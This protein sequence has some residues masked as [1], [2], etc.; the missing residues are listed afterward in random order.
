VLR[1][2]CR[3]ERRPDEDNE[4]HDWLSSQN[5]TRVMKT[6]RIGGGEGALA[7]CVWE[8][9]TVYRVLV[10]KPAGREHLKN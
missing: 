7:A 2:G 5:I 3:P 6:K 10:V 4:F 9:S 1:K 8:K